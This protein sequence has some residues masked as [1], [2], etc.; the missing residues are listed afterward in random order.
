M[1]SSSLTSFTSDFHEASAPADDTPPYTNE[2]GGLSSSGNTGAF[3][4]LA[5][6]PGDSNDRAQ[7][8]TI[9]ISG[10]VPRVVVDWNARFSDP[11]GVD[12]SQRLATEVPRSALAPRRTK[13]RRL[14]N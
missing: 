7:S 6:P 8:S 12:A 3:E 4:V 14:I 13:S 9:A 2:K 10:P 11:E 5:V 1:C